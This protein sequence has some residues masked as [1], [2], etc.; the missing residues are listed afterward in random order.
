M[1]ILSFK[2]YWM[3]FFSDNF[4]E[5]FGIFC[6]AMMP[7]VNSDSYTYFP[8]WI[9]CISFSFLISIL[10]TF[11]ILLNKVVTVGIPHLVP[12]LRGNTFVFSP[13]E[14]DVGFRFL[15]L[16]VSPLHINTFC[17]EVSSR[18]NLFV[19]PTKLA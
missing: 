2:L 15:A 6:A 1:L 3:K 19:S 5:G 12:N 11:K 8:I 7:T 18:G 17:F 14:Y 4:S 10:R 13:V 9:S 16:T